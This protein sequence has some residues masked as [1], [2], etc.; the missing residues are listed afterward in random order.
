MTGTRWRS[1]LLL[2]LVGATPTPAAD[3][4]PTPIHAP[5]VFHVYRDIRLPLN[6]VTP[7]MASVPFI[8][9]NSM[10]YTKLAP[11]KL[12]PNL[13]LYRYRASTRSEQ[14]Q[15]YIDQGLGFY[16]SYVWMEAARSFE[17]ALK[18]DPDCAFAWL[19]LH[20]SIEKWGKGN[21][22]P[23]LEKAKELMPKASHREQFLI[24]ARLEEKGMMPG[25]TPEERVKKATAT[26]DE[27]LTI[28]D[29]DQEGWFYRAQLSPGNGSI[30][31][32]KALLRINPLHP[33]GTHELVH[34]YENFK[35]PALGWPYADAYIQSSPG[36]P[37]PFHM[38]AHL[39]T[40][41][42]KWARTS[43]L[44]ARAVELE[45]AYH[46]F[47][48]VRP[49]D[50]HQYAHHLDIL[51]IS[52]VHDGRF[53]EARAIKAEV[54]RIGG[55]SE[56]L[57]YRLHQ[58]ER[59]YKEAFAI[60]DLFRRKDKTGAS[61]LAALL[62]LDQG[63]TKSAA[64]EID[65]LRL[66]QQ[67]RKTDKKL[68]IRLWEAQGRYLCQTGA[69]D[70]GLKLIERAVL[71]TRDDFGHHSWGNGAY[72][73]ETWGEEALTAG[74]LIVAEEAFLEAL[75]HDPGSV[76]AALGMQ[77][78]CEKLGRTEEAAR[79]ATIARRNWAKADSGRFDAL[80]NEFIQK[81]NKSSPMT[82]GAGSQ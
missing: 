37:H 62:Y 81:V 49:A 34:F 45:R 58:R 6:P 25:I 29:D 32:Y 38:Q 36:I 13:C 33:G 70:E 30:P 21:A 74:K 56:M 23:P 48:N 35:R 44:S 15:A 2:L 18:Y 53:Q 10:Q 14:C 19:G 5:A 50:D 27:L 43:D 3:S 78:L 54:Q 68:E 75:A 7:A 82:A 28:Y 71:K 12:F 11:A 65:V 69:A 16:Y 42:G 73:M 59:D 55:K 26:L 31:F 17:T 46:A 64:P 60:A 61:Y 4:A 9:S 63:D 52:L 57:W 41:L 40:R 80:R 39:A 1:A 77:V 47:Q 72:Y 8:A 20:R 79:F 22:T 76:R 24:R 66:A 51:T 67:Q